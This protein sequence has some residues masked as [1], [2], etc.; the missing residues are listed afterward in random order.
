MRQIEF[1]KKP[2]I[3]LCFFM[4]LLCLFFWLTSRYPELQGKSSLNNQAPLSSLGF[5]TLI[6]INEDASNLEK[7]VFGTVNWAYTNKK[8]MSFAF[9]MGAFFLSLLPF[10]RLFHASGRFKNSFLGLLIGAP[11]GVCVNCSAP[12]AYSLHLSG[13]QLPTTL[14]ALIASP[15]LNVVVVVMMFSIFPFYL[16][17]AKLF[18]TFFFILIIIPLFCRLFF[19]KEEALAIKNKEE[20]AKSDKENKELPNPSIGWG[21]AITWSI[22]AYLKNLFYIVRLALPLMILAGI[23]GSVATTFMPWS[24][25]SELSNDLSLGFMFLIIIGLSFFGVLLPS[26]MAFDVILSSVMLQSG[27]PIVYV[28]VLLFTLGTFSI[29]AFL[30]IWKALSFR[31]AGFLYLMTMILGIVMGLFVASY[32]QNFYTASLKELERLSKDRGVT[33][34]DQPKLMRSDKSNSY[35]ELKKRIKPN[36]FN[37]IVALSIPDDISLEVI[38]FAEQA[39]EDSIKFKRIAGDDLG[40]EQPYKISYLSG[41][42]SGIEHSTMAVAS[43]DVHEDGWQDLLILGDKEVYPNIALYANING[44]YFMRQSLPLPKEL[45][46][47][48]GLALIDINA[49]GML[50]ILFSVSDGSIYKILNDKGSFDE[51]NLSLLLSQEKTKPINLGFADVGGDGDIDIFIG[52]WNVGPFFINTSRSRNKLLVAE[53]DGYEQMSLEGVTGETL[54]SLFYDFNKD[55]F[56]DLFVGNDYILGNNSDLLFLGGENKDLNLAS[57]DMKDKI[58]GAA[59]TMSVDAGDIDNDGTEEF[60]IGQIA[61]LGHYN[62]D[63]SKITDK[64]I[65]Y[66]E[67]CAI[68]NTNMNMELCQEEFFFKESLAKATHFINDACD[69]LT[70]IE[71]KQDCLRHLINY[72]E[73]CSNHFQGLPFQDTPIIKNVIKPYENFCKDVFNALK[74]LKNKDDLKLIDDNNLAKNTALIAGN[75]SRSNLLLA[76]KEMGGIYEDI[77]IERSAGFGAWTW[78]ARFADLDND[79]WQDIYIVNGYTY[80][81]ALP[82]N[83]FYQNNGYG[84]FEDKTEAFGLT[85]F[86]PISAYSYIDYDQD[87]D[88]DIIT[89]PTDAGVRIYKN[90][91]SENKSI[92][93]ELRDYSAKNIYAIG[94][95]LKIFYEDSEGADKIQIRKIKGSGG[96]RSFNPYEAHFGLGKLDRINTLEITWPDGKIQRLDYKFKAGKRYK[97]TKKH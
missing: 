92:I 18:F 31:L 39:E 44:E 95:K 90:N 83:I 87:G 93:F 50:D 59:S 41:L 86:T 37:Q 7:I 57:S 58:V 55:G 85:D 52:N 26:P 33:F 28:A 63:M 82:T 8:G 36:S 45:F 22:R 62:T 9:L 30:I 74:A 34:E 19:K 23:L 71:F 4:L 67:Y 60:Y 79:G 43:G 15:T 16:A 2:V 46:E 75:F 24:D 25:I 70:N 80:P 1:S 76:K 84:Y 48:V 20:I 81:M 77:A 73:N 12:I 68:D 61:Y 47:V 69:K 96:F 72:K 17:A 21:N 51:E 94:S 91:V 53:K 14:A 49:D 78:N 10:L 38:E 27:M 11:L 32:D 3:F 97:I 42:P 65:R 88:L 54:T 5:D 13:A 66:S 89:V 40:I 56:V 35:A 29:Y 64:Q 6:D